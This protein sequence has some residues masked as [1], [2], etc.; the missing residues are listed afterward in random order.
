MTS[1]AKVSV[2]ALASLAALGQRR[3]RA[4]SRAIVD[5]LL[6]AAVVSTESLE[7]LALAL[8][9][10]TLA[11]ALVRARLDVTC[12]S[13]PAR[14][15]ITRTVRLALA[16]VAAIV[17]ALLRAA[18]VTH[19][20]LVAHTLKVSRARA[21][22]ATSTVGPDALL[23]ITALARPPRFALTRAVLLALAVIRTAVRTGQNIARLANEAMLTE[24]L[25][26]HALAVTVASVLAHLGRTVFARPP[27][28][29]HAKLV[30]MALSVPGAVRRA[31]LLVAR[32]ASPSQVALA[33]ARADASSLQVARVRTVRFLAAVA[34]TIAVTQARAIFA[35]HAVI[36]AVQGA[37][38]LQT[39]RP[40]PH[41]SLERGFVSFVDVAAFA[42]VLNA[43]SVRLSSA[44]RRTVLLR[45]VLTLPSVLALALATASAHTVEAALVRARLDVARESGEALLAIASAGLVTHAVFGAVER[46]LASVA[47]IADPHLIFEVRLILVDLV[48]RALLGVAIARSV[49]HVSHAAVHTLVSVVAFAL[50]L[51]T[52]DA[53]ALAVIP[54]LIRTRLDLTSLPGPSLIALT[55][56]LLARAVIAA[57][58]RTSHLT[59]VVPGILGEALDRVVLVHDT[60]VLHHESCSAVFPSPPGLALAR[61]VRVAHAVSGARARARSRLALNTLKSVLTVAHAL[62][63]L[64]SSGAVRNR[65]VLAASNLSTILAVISVV[66][67]THTAGARTS[68]IAVRGTRT[69]L[70]RLVSPSLLALARSGLSLART[71]PGASRIA[72]VPLVGLWALHV[73]AVQ[74]PKSVVAS[75]RSVVALSSAAAVVG[76]RLGRTA[77][78]DPRIVAAALVVRARAV[79]V[80]I[81]GTLF[82][83]ARISSLEVLKSVVAD[84]LSV[85]TVPV[86]IL[87]QLR[88]FLHAA[89]VSLVARIA[90]ALEV[91]ANTSIVAVVRAR[92]F[93]A[94][95]AF[96]S[97]EARTR[98]V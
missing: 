11:G 53:D 48:T 5:A 55:D 47:R 85:V 2:V 91:D 4:V 97:I 82:F 65:L 69:E 40:G 6:L 18:I 8:D 31:D 74:T 92:R 30:V 75:A 37:R 61:S 83:L 81:F 3:A 38:S 73:A 33:L 96:V 87:A 84:T 50:A 79:S 49:K 34:S 58:Q 95:A 46:T 10:Q 98:T 70:A 19:E 43:R 80:A 7:T 15:A 52:A 67:L 90:L 62:D 35:A 89:V 29:A 45:T 64:T 12:L 9:A 41:L 54:T 28:L 63:A 93:E 86:R 36:A 68:L 72:R 26:V 44:V 39:S 21:V 13:G 77:L 88:T 56:T 24:T 1:E 60:V 20:S 71:M 78:A 17:G 16:V 25:S 22:S 14:S 51:L 76:T 66:A 27:L 32:L 42:L 94:V 59:A 57:V 23:D